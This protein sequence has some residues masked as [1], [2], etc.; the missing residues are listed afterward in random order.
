MLINTEAGVMLFDGLRVD[1]VEADYECALVG[2]PSLIHSTTLTASRSKF[3]KLYEKRGIGAI[4]V[5][6]RKL[7]PSFVK[8]MMWRLKC[9]L[10]KIIKR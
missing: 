6:C 5:V 2:N 7:E 1:G 4:P 10:M 3:W 9:G 8:V